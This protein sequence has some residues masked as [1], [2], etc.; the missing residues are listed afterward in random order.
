MDDTNPIR[1]SHLKAF[2]R[3]AAH[4]RYARAGGE[5]EATPAMEKGTALHA[6]LFGTRLVVGYHEGRARRGKEF[7]AFQAEHP[8]AEIL[9]ASDYELACRMAE[10][11]SHHKEAMSL[12]VGPSIVNEQTLRFKNLGR[13]CRATPDARAV[14]FTTELKSTADAS[15]DRFL[16]HAIRMCY[17]GQL[18]WYEEACELLGKPRP[19]DHFIVA[20]EQKP[21]FVVQPFHVNRE[22]ILDAAK[23]NR[24]W[25]E[26]LIACEAAEQFP[27]YCQSVVELERPV[28]DMGLDFSGVEVAAP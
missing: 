5:D 13:L 4:G 25:L 17:P 10:A 8:N 23:T 24:L 18:A 21:P 19:E 22:L 3:S 20:V 27:G 7:E 15:P 16:W 6:I 14:T 12:L 28:D 11:V 2:G 9:T 26:R 1:F